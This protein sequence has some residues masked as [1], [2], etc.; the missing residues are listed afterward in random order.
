MDEL[1]VDVDDGT[2]GGGVEWFDGFYRAQWSA[3]VRLAYVLVD[4]RSV[5]EDLVQDAFARMFLAR[6]RVQDPVPYLRSAVYNACRNHHRNARS[7]LRRANQPRRSDEPASGD[8]VLDAVR[9]L[10]PE[11]RAMVVLRYYCGLTDAEI[12]AVIDVPLGTVKSTLHRSLAELR[13]AL[14]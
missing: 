8:H 1:D 12:S 6:G 4:D 9:R 11:R 5:A 3:M 7:L 10:R 13:K 14:S 2:A